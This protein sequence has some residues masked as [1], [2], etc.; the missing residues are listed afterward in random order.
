MV[1]WEFCGNSEEDFWK[2]SSALEPDDA[3]Y[4]LCLISLQNLFKSY[5]GAGVF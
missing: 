2:V 4:T 1:D 3:S 5:P